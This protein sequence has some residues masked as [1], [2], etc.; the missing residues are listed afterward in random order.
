LRIQ[1][2]RQKTR[3]KTAH[4]ERKISSGWIHC[5]KNPSRDFMVQEAAISHL[6]HRADNQPKIKFKLQNEDEQ[7]QQL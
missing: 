4:H 5:W 6:M 3:I 7:K 2:Q 1:E